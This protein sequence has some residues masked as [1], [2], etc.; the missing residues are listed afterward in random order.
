MNPQDVINMWN[1]QKLTL[2]KSLTPKQSDLNMMMNNVNFMVKIDFNLFVQNS[3]A[4]ASAKFT[5]KYEVQ[6]ENEKDFQVARK[7]IGPKVKILWSELGLNVSSK[8]CNMKKIIELC[9]GYMKALD[10]GSQNQSDL[11]KLRL[12]GKGSGFKEGPG[13]KGNFRT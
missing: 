3:T 1:K 12:R 4:S 8:G 7:I 9:Q 13:Q 6:I 2:S 11:L 5:C 10:V